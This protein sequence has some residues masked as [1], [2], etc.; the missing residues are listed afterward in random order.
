VGLVSLSCRAP[1]LL[2]TTVLLLQLPLHRLTV[3]LEMF[4]LQARSAVRVHLFPPLVLLARTVRTRLPQVVLSVLL[5]STAPLALRTTI[6]MSVLLVTTVLLVHNLQCSILVLWALITFFNL[7]TRAL[8][9]SLVHL[10]VIVLPLEL[11]LLCSAHQATTALVEPPLH[12]QQALRRAVATVLQVNIVQLA[13]LAPSH[14]CLEWRAPLHHCRGPIYLAILAI[15]ALRVNLRRP[16]LLTGV[17]WVA[18]VPC[19][20]SM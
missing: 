8:P 1:A 2:D 16:R 19:R 4:V 11:Q 6:P 3:S 17:P 9:A 15:C 18:F 14:V 20:H 5:A 12:S 7:E 10:E 13:P